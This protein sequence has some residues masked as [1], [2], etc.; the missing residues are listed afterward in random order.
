MGFCFIPT[1][2]VLFI[3]KERENNVKHQ[4]MISGVSLIAYSF[5][6]FVWDLIKS[7]FTA[8]LARLFVM[9]FN[10]SIYTDEYDDLQVM[11]ALMILGVLGQ[12]PF[13]YMFSSFLK[14]HSTA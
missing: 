14:N 3:T 5:S 1:S 13:A 10:I 8:V 11:S 12:V 2:I 6:N 4:Y 7:T 9:A